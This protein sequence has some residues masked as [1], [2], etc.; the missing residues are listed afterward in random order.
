MDS[1]CILFCCLGSS[2]DVGSAK[3]SVKVVTDRLADLL[4][5]QEVVIEGTVSRGNTRERENDTS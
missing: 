3:N 4:G 1:C 2:D 5:S